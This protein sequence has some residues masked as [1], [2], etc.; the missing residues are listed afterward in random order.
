MYFRNVC[1]E[2]VMKTFQSLSDIWPYYSC[3]RLSHAISS[4]DLSLKWSEVQWAWWIIQADI[5]INHTFIQLILSWC[6]AARRSNQYDSTKYILSISDISKSISS[7]P[8]AE[9]WQIILQQKVW[10]MQIHL[11]ILWKNASTYS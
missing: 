5:N 7:N 1:L 6:F 11:F 10:N 4:H 8:S 9:N 3:K 2:N